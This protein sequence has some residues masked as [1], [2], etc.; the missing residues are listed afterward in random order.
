MVTYTPLNET[1]S[2]RFIIDSK[3]EDNPY[4]YD[5]EVALKYSV[6]IDKLLNNSNSIYELLND[7]MFSNSNTKA[8]CI[9]MHLLII[10]MYVIWEILI[11]LIATVILL[12]ME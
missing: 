3:V 2:Y 12:I 1:I 10:L 7:L 4:K 9:E 6:L 11:L 8:K 5:Y